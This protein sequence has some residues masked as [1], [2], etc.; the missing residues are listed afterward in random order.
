MARITI[1]DIARRAEVST[2]AVSYA[3][4]DRPGV[5]ATT[6][7]RILAIAAEMGWQPS[8]AARSL[9][10]ARA[11]TIGLILA[12]APETLG[13][14]SFYMQFVAGIEQ[15][16]SERSYGLLLQVVPDVA[17]EVA[18]HRRW[19]AARRVDGVVVVDPRT[20]DPRLPLL[21]GADA[22][23]AVVVGDPG[24]A[25]GATA[26]WTDDGTAL[27]E[28]VRYLVGLGHRRIGRVSGTEEFGHTHIRDLAFDDETRSHGVVSRSERADFTPEAGAAAARA[29]LTAADPVTAIVFD[30]DVMALAGL[31]VAHELGVRVPQ[32]LSLVAWD[33]SPLCEAAFPQLT[34]LS[35]DVTSYGA[36][37]ARRLFD[38]MEGA[39]AASFLDAT[40][41]LRVR[42]STGPAPAAD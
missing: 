31:G 41:V 2:G 1:A 28:C 25:G 30:N 10:G 24:L 17:A 19:R 27:R 11:E 33:D 38:R 32:D 3:L 29:L 13:F 4:N 34:A 12:R 6:R 7:E 8:Q 16:L 20:D 9:S 18:A 15:V 39:P 35:H 40:P 22:L 23:P 37:V 14:E 26:V 5:S 42:G 36:H 21:L